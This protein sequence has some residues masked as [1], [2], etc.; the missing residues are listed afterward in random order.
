MIILDCFMWFAI[1]L[2][3]LGVVIGVCG[4]TSTI[5]KYFYTKKRNKMI[6]VVREREAQRQRAEKYIND[7]VR[8]ITIFT[9]PSC[10]CSVSK[11]EEDDTITEK[12]KA[13]KLIV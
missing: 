12:I 4:F 1:L 7:H 2:M 11:P 13:R 5:Y 10:S 8:D 3:V 9:G 6:E